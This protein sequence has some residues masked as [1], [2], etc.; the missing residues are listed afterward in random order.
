[1]QQQI[2]AVEKT[3]G[4]KGIADMYEEVQKEIGREK[5]DH[6]IEST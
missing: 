4:M 2:E 1:M 5:G 6:G 3:Q